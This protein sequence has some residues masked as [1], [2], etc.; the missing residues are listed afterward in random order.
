MCQILAGPRASGRWVGVQ[1]SMGSL[2]GIVAPAATGFI[3]QATGR[4]TNAFIAAAAVSLLGLI[5]WLWMV[6]KLAPLSWHRVTESQA[7][8]AA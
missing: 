3:V 1:N 2:A 6:P 4:Y 7:A 8:E 5:G